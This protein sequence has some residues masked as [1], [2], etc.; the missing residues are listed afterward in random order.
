MNRFATFLLFAVFVMP[1]GYSFGEDT[2]IHSAISSKNRKMLEQL[3]KNGENV[4]ITDDKRDTP[5]LHL[6][7]QAEQGTEDTE[8]DIVE[9]AK[10]LLEYKSNPNVVSDWPNKTPLLLA[11][12]QGNEKLMDLLL[13]YGADINQRGIWTPG[14]SGNTALHAAAVN[15]NEEAAK[16]LLSKG[17]DVNAKGTNDNT[18]L[19]HAVK[20]HLHMVELLVSNSADVNAKNNRGETPLHIIA[21]LYPQKTWAKNHRIEVMKILLEAGADLEAKDRSGKTPL[22]IA[23]ESTYSKE[24]VEI[25]SKYGAN[26]ENMNNIGLKLIAIPASYSDKELKDWFDKN[27]IDVNQKDKQGV[28]LLHRAVIGGKE[29]IIKELLSRGA[30]VNAVDKQAKTALHLAVCEP[31]SN[32]VDLLIKYKADVNARDNNGKTP[33]H[34]LAKTITIGG[35]NIE[36][37]IP[38]ESLILLLSNGAKVDIKDNRGSSPLEQQLSWRPQGQNGR[39]YRDEMIKLLSRHQ[40][41]LPAKINAAKKDLYNEDVYTRRKAAIDLYYLGDY[42]GVPIMIE[43]LKSKF[44][45]N[46]S[47]ANAVLKEITT[48]DFSEGKSL[49]QLSLDEEKAAIER[50]ITWWEQN[51]TN[52]KADEVTGFAEV[53]KGEAKA[54]ARY[55]A[56]AREAER[57]NP[58]LPTFD[59]L[60]KTP[61]ATLEKFK[62]AL[63]AGDDEKAL[64]Y[65]APH[66]AEKYREIFGQLGPHRRDFVEGMGNIYFD[67]E[68]S[69]VLYYE[70]L[71]EQDVGRFSFPI[72]FAQD[73]DGNWIITNF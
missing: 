23:A 15:G 34:Y 54:R 72:H 3:L 45:N 2:T 13:E 38:K 44:K 10:L 60:E 37:D 30:N 51:K 4:D 68:L 61:H 17:A 62:T 69:N 40:S 46:R 42:S 22:S 1:V 29:K 32:I 47:V 18:P 48:Q 71:S 63:L 8:W 12:E 39:K 27:V 36:R 35:E 70:M 58:D 11:A 5:L 52:I 41:D 19:H 7:K 55:H 67:M 33:L 14:Q 20:R 64:S 26:F 25:L 43:S 24:S 6:I 49:R 73:L 28:P 16:L 57:N 59:D 53:L 31:Q 65:M 66:I 50:W 21:G 9:I 56:A